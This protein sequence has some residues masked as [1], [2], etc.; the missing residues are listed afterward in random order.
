MPFQQC[1]SYLQTTILQ[2]NFFAFL[3]IVWYSF[4][5]FTHFGKVCLAHFTCSTSSTSFTRN[6]NEIL[7]SYLSSISIWNKIS[8]K[9]LETLFDAIFNCFHKFSRLA[10]VWL[11][12]HMPWTSGDAKFFW[13]FLGQ[14]ALKLLKMIAFSFVGKLFESSEERLCPKKYASKIQINGNSS[15]FEEIWCTR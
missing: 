9:C 10:A 12:A 2:P 5:H 15:K 4:L 1:I 3:A 8:R 14:L 13:C 7:P 6:F 11:S